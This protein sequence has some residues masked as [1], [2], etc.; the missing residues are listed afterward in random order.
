MR[1]A[2]LRTLVLA[3]LA[4]I[5]AVAAFAITATNSIPSSSLGEQNQSTGLRDVEPAACRNNGINPT[6]LIIAPPG[7]GT[8]NGTTGSDLIL[9]S[10]GGGTKIDGGGGGDCL[11]A[12]SATDLLKGGADKGAVDVCVKNGNPG[13][14]TQSCSFT[15]P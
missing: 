11:V 10:G 15:A 2:V 1:V 8:T 3:L 13:A 6:R 14:K 7:V 12:A 9:S 5:L 4:V